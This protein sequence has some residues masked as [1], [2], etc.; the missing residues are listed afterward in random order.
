M[1]EIIDTGGTNYPTIRLSVLDPKRKRF[2]IEVPAYASVQRLIEALLPEM[3]LPW[4]ND[5]GEYIDYVLVSTRTGSEHA[6]Q[7]NLTLGE[8]GIINEDT[9]LLQVTPR[10]Q[11]KQNI[12]G[13][14][15]PTQSRP[16]SV[17]SS[18]FTPPQ[19]M[20]RPV[21]QLAYVRDFITSE[22]FGRILGGGD[23]GVE[24]RDSL[25][26]IQ[27]LLEKLLSEAGAQQTSSSASSQPKPDPSSE[28]QSHEIRDSLQAIQG[29]LEKFLSEAG[30]QQT[31][32]S[33]PSQPE[34]DPSP[35]VQSHDD[36]RRDSQ[37]A[38]EPSSREVLQAFDE[39]RNLVESSALRHESARSP[40][41]TDRDL[42]EICEKI[43]SQ[44]EE[45]IRGVVSEQTEASD[46]TIRI[47]IPLEEKSPVK[48][49][50]I[51]K[52][53]HFERY[54][55]EESKWRS[56]A[57]FF[58]GGIL[59]VLVNWATAKNHEVSEV[60]LV[61]VGFCVLI[62]GYCFLS[63]NDSRR[64]AE[65]FKIDETSSKDE[66]DDQA[67]RTTTRSKKAGSGAVRPSGGAKKAP[68]RARKPGGG[69]PSR[70]AGH[71]GG[72]G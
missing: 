57:Q 55:N 68:R 70:P 4:L 22:R 6:L 33:A 14:G 50:R 27:G 26:A 15:L 2:H 32:S 45:R 30:A 58:A 67:I 69:A 59:G 37:P 48:M 49:V 28:P 51:E 41:L 71:R 64:T 66:S 1:S 12:T 52:L 56:K 29:L 72:A 40:E 43:I 63:A 46:N 20:T 54:R 39:L 42:E 18:W 25:Q 21:K 13:E 10:H 16:A 60:S 23:L 31:S 17:V 5:Q 24:I 35:E 65:E 44:L 9:L 3:E 53:R 7:P 19:D 38:F 62:A 34:L 11:G 61:V 47:E 36:V 8:A